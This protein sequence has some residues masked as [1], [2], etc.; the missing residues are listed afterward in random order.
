MA[1]SDS[2][3][4]VAVLARFARLLPAASE[5]P[6]ILDELMRSAID[7]LEP[8]GVTVALS[9]QLRGDRSEL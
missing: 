8:G 9:A 4:L 3:L 2:E 7:V 1:V 6:E 5:L